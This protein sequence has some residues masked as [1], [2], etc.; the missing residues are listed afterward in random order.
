MRRFWPR[1]QEGRGNRCLLIARDGA[2]KRIDQVA[3]VLN[4][5]A[6]LVDVLVVGNRPRSGAKRWDDGFGTH[7]DHGAEVAVVAAFVGKQP[8]E[9]LNEGLGLLAVVISPVRQNVTQPLP[10][11]RSRD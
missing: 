6:L 11:G 7:S 9:A 1:R 4:E 3:K 8:V 5:F 2:G 10:S